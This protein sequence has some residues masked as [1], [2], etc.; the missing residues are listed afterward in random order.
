MSDKRTEV[1]FKAY[2]QSSGLISGGV[3]LPYD[4]IDFNEGGGTYS[5]TEY[6]YTIP[7]TGTYLI[8]ATHIRGSYAGSGQ[9]ILQVNRSGTTTNIN[10]T[11]NAEG[12]TSSSTGK[13]RMTL[14]H[15]TMYDFEEGDI[16]FVRSLYGYT[17]VAMN[18][19]TYSGND[20]KNSFWGIRLDWD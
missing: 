4:Q 9:T 15:L 5:T 16:L 19:S 11:Q 8:G 17:R 3:N 14:T 6:T 7:K 18:A 12:G 1:R 10:L 20:I 2:N 13:Q